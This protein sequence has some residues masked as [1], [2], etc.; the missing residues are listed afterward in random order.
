MENEKQF[1]LSCVD[2]SSFSQVVSDYAAWIAKTVNVPLR[3]LHTI[4][5]RNIPPVTDLS[6]TIG[7]GASE[8]L[9]IELTQLEESRSR[10]LVKKGNIMLQAAKERA[11]EAG[12]D[13]V[14]IE[15]RHGNLTEALVEMEDAIRVLVVGIRGESHDDRQTG[16]GTQLETIVRSLHKPILVVNKVFE[17][18]KKIM[19]AYDGSDA[20]KKALSMVASSLLFKSIP[21][22][23]IHVVNA[24]AEQDPVLHEA[25]NILRDAGISVS[26][27]M[28]RGKIDEVL[29]AYQA[30][31]DIDLTVMGAFSHNRVRDFLLGS[32]TAKMLASTQKPLLLLR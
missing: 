32:F 21:C 29:S 15:Q 3:L 11:L 2:G 13:I 14:N 22:H 16:V 27:I 25:E 7:L 10:L 1:V 31:H 6:G 20:A 9:L 12:V 23:L 8:E 26:G 17:R 30:E 28:L 19:L 4:E 24:D 18:P 5:H